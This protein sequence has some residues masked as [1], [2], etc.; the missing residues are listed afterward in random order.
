MDTQSFSV[1]NLD[2]NTFQIL[3]RIPM[4]FDENTAI[5]TCAADRKLL[6]KRPPVPVVSVE[7]V[8]HGILKHEVDFE[9]FEVK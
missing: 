4:K 5:V 2:F 8:F 1:T 6:P 9:T 3:T 7:F